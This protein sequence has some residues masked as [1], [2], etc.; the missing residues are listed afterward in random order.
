MN[1]RQ[2]VLLSPYRLPAQ[3]PL[4]LANEDMAAW[5]NGYSALWHPAALRRACG[6][7]RVE[8]PYD[9]EHPRPGHVYAVPATPPSMLP[10]DWAERIRR[11]GAVTFQSLPDRAATLAN[12]K[13][14]LTAAPQ[15]AGE[16]PAVLP[17]GQDDPTA[18]A[19]LV[20]LDAKA[21]APFLGLGTGYMLL[22]ALSE[23]MEHENLL[24]T[25]DF[26]IDIQ[27]AVAAVAGLPVTVEAAVAE[28]SE[29]ASAAGA[30]DPVHDQTASTPPTEESPT[31][32]ESNGP[33]ADRHLQSA[34]TRLLSARETLYPVT[35][36]LLDLWVLDDREP[37][38]TWPAVWGQPINLIAAA[39]S[40]EKL[41]RA[42][43]ERFA[44][45]VELV[46]SGHAE[47]CG[48]N[49]LEREDPL[50]PVESQ[51]WNLA[52]GL[53][54]TRELVGAEPTVFARRRFGVHPQLPGWLNHHG[55]SHALLLTLDDSALPG[56]SSTVVNWS[57]QDG[58]HIDCFVKKPLPA[59]SVDT[60]FNLGHYLFKTTRE[61][62]TATLAL[63]HTTTSAAQP[64]Y[65]DLM[66]LARFGSITGTWTTFSHYFGECSTGDYSGSIGPDE[67]HFD[68]LSERVPQQAG[69]VEGQ[70]PTVRPYPSSRPV[71]GFP[72]QARLRRRIDT[73]W[74][75]A[76]IHRGLAGKQD[77]L[78]IDNDLTAVEDALEA[79]GAD[80]PPAESLTRLENLERQIATALTDRLLARAQTPTPGWMLLN[81]CGFTRRLA[82]EL[83]SRGV[84]LPVQ[85]PVKACQLDGDKLRAVVEVPPLGFAW[86]PQAGPPGTPP[87]P[88]R[89]RLADER[90][91]RNEFFE[92]EIDQATGG[93]RAI[94]DHKTLI[95]RISQRLIF[96][97][98]STMKATKVTTTSSGPALGEI[99]TEGVLLGAQGQALAKFKQRFR[100]WLGRPILDLRIELVPEQPPAGYPWH[101]YFGAQFAWRDERAMLL[102]GLGASSHIST[103]LRPQTPEFLEFRLQRQS[104]TIFP[105]GLPFHQREGGR[106]LDVIL[107]PPGESAQVFDLAIGL[108]RD[109]PAQTALGLVTPATVVPTTKGPPHVGTKGWLFHL[110]ASNLVLTSLR[111]GGRE[112]PQEGAPAPDLTDAVT[113]RLIECAGFSTP[114]E[115]RCVRNPQRVALLDARGRLLMDG[116]IT[117]DAALFQAG[118]GEIL[119]VQV[120]FSR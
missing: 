7:P 56:Y 104:T 86:I 97:P 55:I 73:C 41:Q 6:P 24:E 90:T 46:R 89:M 109:Q 100:A 74:T 34:A 115:L 111:P 49:Y 8:S 75:L 92:A 25:N 63:L 43:P 88:Q 54:I 32:V 70:E 59:E 78:R 84:P 82:L 36:H 58:K 83:E 103:H 16:P 10:D 87:P 5:L 51:L 31:P 99:I 38:A 69:A 61:D 116:T 35:I 94:R 45:L 96:R 14:A 27:L 1:V 105:G 106:M 48:G 95:N 29:S 118:P 91:V 22:A 107:V 20:E 37:S 50:L 117:N 93:L 112:L 3:H 30:D 40:L 11:A 119:E 18:T 72:E 57:T 66:E 23:A 60:F 17:P 80:L 65:A 102:R 52:K 9:H 47:V 33:P 53:R 113:A 44:N 19:Q 26:W 101:A 21:A 79:V 64:W 81:P 67:F 114:A 68:Y 39:A 108:D 62:H 76:A 28:H 4:T 13:T 77:P 42:D 71:S 98:G 15:P 12:L 2:L 110:D 85:D 120:E